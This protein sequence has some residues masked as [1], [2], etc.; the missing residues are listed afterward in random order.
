MNHKLEPPGKLKVRPCFG[1]PRFLSSN[2][3]EEGSG[4]PGR[5]PLLLSLSLS[6]CDAAIKQEIYP[7]DFSK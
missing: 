4:R 2:K 3:S 6:Q 7:R 5:F 1:S